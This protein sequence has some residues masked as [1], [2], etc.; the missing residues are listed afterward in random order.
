VTHVIVFNIFDLDHLPIIFHILYHVKV[1]IFSDPI[2]KFTDWD[3][4]QS[5]A[6]EVISPKIEIK[7]EVE[8]DK[9][10][11]EFS[12]SISSAHR[13]ST[14]K[15]TL[16]DLNNDLTGLTQEEDKKIVAKNQGSSM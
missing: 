15:I 12:A 2:E 11:R 10:A 7:S 14:S 5:L 8:A 6:S 1:R 4:F 3:R 13:L 9:A 16:L